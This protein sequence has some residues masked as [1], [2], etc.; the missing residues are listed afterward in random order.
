MPSSRKVGIPADYAVLMLPSKRHISKDQLFV[1]ATQFARLLK[2]KKVTSVA[3][4]IENRVECPELM[5][6]ARW[7]GADYLICGTD[8]L[9]TGI[10]LSLDALRG[11]LGDFGPDMIVVSGKHKKIAQH[12]T[13]TLPDTQSLMMGDNLKGWQSYE[14]LRDQQPTTPLAKLGAGEF[15]PATGGSTGQPKVIKVATRL[16]N[17]LSAIQAIMT[18]DPDGTVLVPG[19][20]YGNIYARALLAALLSGARAVVMDRW[21]SRLFLQAIEDYKVTL[22]SVAPASMVQLL[23]LPVAERQSYDLSSIKQ[24]MHTG[25]PCPD[26]VKRQFIDWFGDRLKEVYGMTERLGGTIISAAEWL[27]HPGSVGRAFPGC[28]VVI[29][30]IT[31]GKKLPAHQNGIVW[32]KQDAEHAP[33]TYM[34]REDSSA[35]YNEHGEGTVKDIGYVDKDGFLYITGRARRVTMVGGINVFPEATEKFLASQ[36]GVVDTW[37]F[38][39]PDQAN[40]ERLWAFVQPTAHTPPSEDLAK[41]LINACE[42]DLGVYASPTRI[43]F[44]DALPRT[45]LGKLNPKQLADMEARAIE[46]ADV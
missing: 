37:V 42:K 24:I 26:S 41:K 18:P 29:R 33:M 8:V 39:G 13:D 14:T 46:S 21:D 9:T 16:D 1:R 20:L 2:S 12:L 15:H 38:S 31:T 45:D 17:K 3:L 6:G 28:Q 36:P 10:R 27:D 11:I 34:G 30:D 7:A 23:Q 25:A 22:T 35:C 5:L 44:V 40:G 19:P 4:L 43:I 32:F